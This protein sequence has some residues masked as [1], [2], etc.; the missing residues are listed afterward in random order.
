MPYQGK[1]VLGSEMLTFLRCLGAWPPLKITTCKPLTLPELTM[2][3]FPFPTHVVLVPMALAVW[4]LSPANTEDDSQY[5]TALEI[6]RIRRVDS[7]TPPGMLGISCSVVQQPRLQVC[8]HM[9]SLAA[10][11]RESYSADTCHTSPRLLR[12]QAH[13]KVSTEPGENREECK[14]V[15]NLLTLLLGK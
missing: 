13:S 9:D 10:Q 5:I 11:G 6:I 2:T 8:S 1:S 12:P 14:L 3:P 15:I 4:Q 7:K